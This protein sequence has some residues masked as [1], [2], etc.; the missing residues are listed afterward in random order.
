MLMYHSDE[1]KVLATELQSLLQ[2]KCGTTRFA[3]VYAQVRS[4]I[5]AVRD[6]RRAARAV[7]SVKD[8]RASAVRKRKKQEKLKEVK[9]G[10]KKRKSLVSQM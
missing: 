10:R 7:L 1:L 2:A 5:I 6:E 3:E 9:K 8:P 4:G